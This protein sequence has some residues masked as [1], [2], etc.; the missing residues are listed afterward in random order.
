MND[1][2]R[3][4]LALALS[5]LILVGVFFVPW[6]IDG[7]DV[8]TWAPAYRQPI[9]SVRSYTSELHDT[10]YTYTEGEVAVGILVLQLL[11]VGVVSGAV[12]VV[13]GDNKK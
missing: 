1:R 11:A 3:T 5:A 12:F 9:S 8:I 13:S 6:Q 7:T 2:Q 10:S 4:V